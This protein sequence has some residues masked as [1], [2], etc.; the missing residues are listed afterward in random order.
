ML[1]G[2]ICRYC[3]LFPEPPGRGSSLGVGS[4]SGVLVL[5]PYKRPYSKAL[6]KDE[7]TSMHCGS[8]EKADLF[9]RNFNNPD[10]RIDSRI[11][12]QKDQ[13]TE[14]NRHVLRQI[15]LAVEFLA[16]QALP[17]RGHSD[18]RVDFS[19]ECQ[20]GQF[21]CYTAAFGQDR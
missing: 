11:M 12:K 4:R 17:F 10:E 1:A 3:T 16:K 15:V 7:Q 20:Q 13:Q 5:S 21:Y 14:E 8:A 2:G 9:L 19:V 18:E 6:G